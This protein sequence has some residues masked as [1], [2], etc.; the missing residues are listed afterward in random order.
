MA[1]ESKP[2]KSEKK[3]GGRK[4][5]EPDVYYVVAIDGWDWSYLLSLNTEPDPVDP[6]HEYRHLRPTLVLGA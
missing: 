4:P 6:Y 5:R 1:I 3:K 2:T